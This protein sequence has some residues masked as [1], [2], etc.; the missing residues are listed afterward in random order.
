M[1]GPFAGHRDGRRGRGVRRAGH[2]LL[3][4][5]FPDA[6]AREMDDEDI[7]VFIEKLVD[8][9]PGEEEDLQQ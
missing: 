6:A 2:R 3:Q 8:E 9:E 7:R 4:A 1:G 5:I